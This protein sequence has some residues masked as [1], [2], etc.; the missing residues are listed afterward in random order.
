MP[1]TLG[2]AGV[3]PVWWGAAVVVLGLGVE[4]VVW[5]R[6]GTVRASRSERTG[7]MVFL[8]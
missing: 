6:A 7:F 8:W 4:V 2:G 1:A 3:A 5:A